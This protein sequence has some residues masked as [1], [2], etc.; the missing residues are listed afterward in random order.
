VGSIFNTTTLAFK[1]A[2]QTTTHL[3]EEGLTHGEG[4]I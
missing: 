4:E 1:V 3:I 2:S